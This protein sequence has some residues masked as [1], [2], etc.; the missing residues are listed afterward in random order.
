M[1]TSLECQK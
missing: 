1:Y